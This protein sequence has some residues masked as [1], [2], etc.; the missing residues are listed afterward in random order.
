MQIEVEVKNCQH[1]FISDRRVAHRA[2]IGAQCGGQ[3]CCAQ[4]F[5]AMV[6]QTLHV[7][8]VCRL[9]V[10]QISSVIAGQQYI[11]LVAPHTDL[12]LDLIIGNH[13]RLK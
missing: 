11:G 3:T 2:V 10:K 6:F 5:E 12:I 13:L 8:I 7:R 1:N 4:P 9:L